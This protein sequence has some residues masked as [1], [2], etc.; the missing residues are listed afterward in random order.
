M[1]R[2]IT[3]DGREVCFKTSAA[4]P[5]LYRKMY[6]RDVLVDM[7]KLVQLVQGPK[8]KKGKEIKSINSIPLEGLDLFE[9]L[10]YIMA[11]HADPDGVPESA[12]E[13]LE[14]FSSMSIYE[15]FPVIQELWTANMH[16]IN[17]PQK[18]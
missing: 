16:Q 10:A 4:L 8:P 17:E 15:V 1:E 5:R 11:K 9:D 12:D 13:W 6:G 14:G 7:A 3:I 2:V 18:K